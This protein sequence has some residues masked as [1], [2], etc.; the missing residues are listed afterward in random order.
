M[1]TSPPMPAPPTPAPP[2]TAS[3]H[4]TEVPSTTS[5][6]PHTQVPGATVTAQHR[7][8]DILEVVENIL[9]HLPIKDLFIHQRV[10]KQFQAAIK[11]PACQKKMFIAVSDTPRECWELIKSGKKRGRGKTRWSFACV[12]PGSD[13]DPGT[14]TPATL[15]PI[16]EVVPGRH[17]HESCAQRKRSGSRGIERVLWR[18]REP[19]VG[20]HSSLL[21]TY[22]SDPPCK[23]LTVSAV[24]IPS[25]QGQLHCLFHENVMLRSETGL[26]LGDIWDR[27]P[28]ASGE[29]WWVD[30][31]RTLQQ[32]RVDSLRK[33]LDDERIPGVA[34]DTPWFLELADVVVPTAKEWAA[35]RQRDARR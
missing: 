4:Y 34:V 7:A 17:A 35:V 31:N 25:D 2:T 33:L 8:L 28:S 23:A 27:A 22:I 26:K 14:T 13:D 11:S 21:N 15:N 1:Q 9:I 10:S 12:D 20:P 6:Q 16:L 32:A 19:T 3:S 18:V 5:D 30:D 24:F 29:S